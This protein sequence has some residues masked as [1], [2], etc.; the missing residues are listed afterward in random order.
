MYLSS[1]SPKLQAPM[2]DMFPWK[3]DKTARYPGNVEYE[4][5]WEMIGERVLVER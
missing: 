2:D 4:T 5:P 3:S 1:S